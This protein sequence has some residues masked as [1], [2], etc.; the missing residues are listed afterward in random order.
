MPVSFRPLRKAVG[1]H[2][3]TAGCGD[4]SRGTA[5]PWTTSVC[6]LRGNGLGCK[7]SLTVGRV[8]SP[9]NSDS[10]RAHSCRVNEPHLPVPAPDQSDGAQPPRA[11]HPVAVDVR[12][13]RPVARWPHGSLRQ[14][15]HPAGVEDTPPTPRTTRI[16]ARP[17]C[18]GGDR[19]VPRQP[20]VN[21]HAGYPHGSEPASFACHRLQIAPLLCSRR[22]RQSALVSMVAPGIGPSR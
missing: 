19:S 6:W 8:P 22:V 15:G 1:G 18:P 12:V 4:Q 20:S 9:T 17:R 11:G 14:P 21:A 7:H 2:D 3:C 16:A 10:L 13:N 5:V